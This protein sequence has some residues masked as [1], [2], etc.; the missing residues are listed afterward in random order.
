[1]SDLAGPTLSPDLIA[2]RTYIVMDG[3]DKDFELNLAG[4]GNAHHAGTLLSRC[5]CA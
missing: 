1:M 2:S 3:A 4:L 5:C